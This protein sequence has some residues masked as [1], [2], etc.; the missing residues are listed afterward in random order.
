MDV[1]VRETGANSDLPA[2]RPEYLGRDRPARRMPPVAGK[3][4]RR[5][6]VPRPTPVRTQRL[7]Q[8]RAQQ[9]VPV[10]LALAAADVNHHPLADVAHLQRGNLGSACPRGV[11]RN[12]QDALK[13]DL[14]GINQARTSA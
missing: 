11:Q 8:R 13:R 4:P 6:L 5:R 14:G 2:G 9:H 12:D 10:P 7:E 3:Q 1:L